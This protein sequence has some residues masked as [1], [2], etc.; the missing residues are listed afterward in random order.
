LF[1]EFRY[2]FCLSEDFAA[3]E[4]FVAVLEDAGSRFEEGIGGVDGV[5]AE[6]VEAGGIQDG[7]KGGEGQ[8]FPV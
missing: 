6:A 4:G 3:P 1:A 7:V 8:Q 5:E 2:L